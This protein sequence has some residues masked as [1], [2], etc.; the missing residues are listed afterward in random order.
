MTISIVGN[1]HVVALKHAADDFP[2]DFSYFWSSGANLRD[3]IVQD[4]KL[5]G[6]TERLR[7]LLAKRSA[8]LGKRLGKKLNWKQARHLSSLAW[9]FLHCN[10]QEPTR[11]SDCSTT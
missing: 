10:L 5:L 8:K 3:A 7:K 9:A 11:R 6:G 1:S 2:L 4:G